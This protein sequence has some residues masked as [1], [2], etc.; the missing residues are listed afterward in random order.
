[1]PKNSIVVFKTKIKKNTL[2]TSTREDF[3]PIKKWW[4]PKFFEKSLEIFLI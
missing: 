2:Q 4:G 3:K 1:V